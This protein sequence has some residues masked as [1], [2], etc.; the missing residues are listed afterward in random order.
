MIPAYEGSGAA[1]RGIPGWYLGSGC[2]TVCSA[3]GRAQPALPALSAWPVALLVQT[4]QDPMSS[5][6]LTWC[7]SVL[8]IRSCPPTFL[9]SLSIIPTHPS[10]FRAPP[11]INSSILGKWSTSSFPTRPRGGRGPIDP[12]GRGPPTQVQRLP[13]PA[14]RRRPPSSPARTRMRSRPM[15]SPTRVRLSPSAAASFAC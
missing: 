5:L 12:G 14:S 2:R 6:W 4:E 9:P 1:I 11:L 3:Q 7:A 10:F 8:S 15:S 13:R